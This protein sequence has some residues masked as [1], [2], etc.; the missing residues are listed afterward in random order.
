MSTL[1]TLTA[2]ISLTG[3]RFVR[4]LTMAVRPG[5]RVRHRGLADLVQNTDAHIWNAVSVAQLSASSGK[6]GRSPA[7]R[8]RLRSLER[9]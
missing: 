2:P 5:C 4:R 9:A 1:R 7:P 3:F 8:T 6:F